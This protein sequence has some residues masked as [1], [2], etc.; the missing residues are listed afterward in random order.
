MTATFGQRSQRQ[1]FVIRWLVF[2]AVGLT[3]AALSDRMPHSEAAKRGLTRLWGPAL[4]MSYPD[5][6]RSQVT[7]LLLDD[8]DLDQYAEVWPAPLGFHKRRLVELLKYRPKA[9][10]FDFIFLDDRND[11]DLDSFIGAA[12]RA[13]ISGTRIFIGSFG[14]AG[15]APTRTE[16][17]M[18]ARRVESGGAR[19]PCIEPAYMNLTIDGYDQSVWEYDLELAGAAGQ[20][21]KPHRYP[22]PAARLYA[23]DHP[24]ASSDAPET[25]MA[26][27]WGT[28]T[29]P[30]NLAWM[31]NDRNPGGAGASCA[32]TWHMSRMLPM[33][34]MGSPICPYSRTLPLRAL[35]PNSGVDPE[36]M[37]Q[38][39]AGNYIIY[40]AALQSNGD[41]VVSPYHGRIPGA[42]V[43]AMAL[44]N[45]LSFQG[46]PKTGGDFLE[47]PAGRATW[48]TILAVFAISAFIAAKSVFAPALLYSRRPPRLEG[49]SEPRNPLPRFPWASAIAA[50]LHAGA[51]RALGWTVLRL[52]VMLA[53][54]LLIATLVAVSYFGMDLG[55]L[56]WIE[57]VLFPLAA[58]FIGLGERAEEMLRE[59][60]AHVRKRRDDLVLA[61]APVQ[62]PQPGE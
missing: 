46:K 48:F 38:A 4:T 30:V 29:H 51:L 20:L 37:Q 3:L 61:A 19:V 13:R 26:I 5:V 59:A 22:S 60:Y 10:F 57:Y 8:E 7:V 6:G 34:R 50:T 1:S 14:N 44:D 25:P 62:S 24:P 41:T 35:K 39:V 9:V 31:N 17:A 42:Y 45:L 21:E 54:V 58:D 2:V 16:A 47:P 49:R 32:S 11:P 23:T 15:I 12:C 43:H 18:L 27:V 40:G 55:P 52:P 56:V 36:D 53:G 33:M 28:E